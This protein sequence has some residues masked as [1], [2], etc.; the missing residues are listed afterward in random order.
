M[1]GPESS[2]VLRR[3]GDVQERATWIG[4]SMTMT[5]IQ[6]VSPTERHVCDTIHHELQQNEKP[7]NRREAPLLC[8][9][10]DDGE[11][12]GQGNETK[13]VRQEELLQPEAFDDF[14][15]EKP[16]DYSIKRPDNPKA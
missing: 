4:G 15:E 3:G 8:E 14:R 6:S 2:G 1:N 16:L 11:C 5:R 13:Q 7:D 9:A 12:G 10:A